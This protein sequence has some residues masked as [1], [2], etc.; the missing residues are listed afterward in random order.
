MTAPLWLLPLYMK[1]FPPALPTSIEP[2]LLGMP[3]VFDR[4]AAGSNRASFQFH[5]SGNEPGDYVLKVANGRCESFLGTTPQPDVTVHTPDAVWIRIAR[6]ELDGTRALQ[7]GLY[8]ADG[9]FTLLPRLVEW[10]P[11]RH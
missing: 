11:G 6:G 1:V 2:I 7:E 8:R 4:K 9:D 3:M 10:F 5:V